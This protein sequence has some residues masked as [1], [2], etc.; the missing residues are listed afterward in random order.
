M[1]K[2]N[3]LVVL[4]VLVFLV[5]DIGGATKG[6][7]STSPSLDRREQLKRFDEALE[8]YLSHSSLSLRDVV[9]LAALY[10]LREDQY[11]QGGEVQ[12]LQFTTLAL[13]EIEKECSNLS[14]LNRQYDHPCDTNEQYQSLL[15]ALRVHE[16]RMLILLGQ[17]REA[18]HKGIAALE[19]H[20][21]RFGNLSVQ[22][23]DSEVWYG[24]PSML[25]YPREHF[26]IEEDIRSTRN[27]ERY[28]ATHSPHLQEQ[29][30]RLYNTIG[31][32][33]LSSGEASRAVPYFL[34]ALQLA[35]CMHHAYFQ[36]ARALQSAKESSSSNTLERDVAWRKEQE[37]LGI[38]KLLQQRTEILLGGVSVKSV[39]QQIDEVDNTDIGE[40]QLPK[41]S[42]DTIEVIYNR[43]PVSV[44]KSA[45]E[46]DPESEGTCSF[47]DELTYLEVLLRFGNLGPW[48][49]AAQASSHV[50]RSALYWT[51]F[52]TAESIG[53]F[54]LAWFYLQQGR[55]LERHRIYQLSK[56]ERSQ[57]LSAK[58]NTQDSDS[59]IQGKSPSMEQLLSSSLSEADFWQSYRQQSRQLAYQVTRLYF[60]QFWPPITKSNT[61]SIVAVES[62]QS[63]SNSSIP[64]FIVGFFRSGS[65]LLESLLE[66]HPVV[67]ALGE[68]SP[69]AQAVAL[70]LQPLA[71]QRWNLLQ[72]YLQPST[73]AEAK[74]NAK[75]RKQ[76][77][78]EE[79]KVWH[80]E[81]QLV[82]TQIQE[83]SERILQ[84]MKSWTRNLYNI[85]DTDGTEL[86]SSSVYRIVDKMLTN[87]RHI[88]L[89]HWVFP[90]ALILH[91][92]RD[93]ID[94]LL[95]CIRHRF[96][97]DHAA[98]TLDMESLV[99]EYVAYLMVMQHFRRILPFREYPMRKNRVDRKVKEED[100]SSE[101]I[102]ER[103]VR[104]GF[105]DVR[106]E[107]LVAEPA[108]YFQDILRLL[109]LPP[110]DL[111]DGSIREF[112]RFQS[113]RH[114]RT[115]SFLQVKQPISHRT[116]G[117][118]RKYAKQLTPTLL[119][120][121][122]EKLGMLREHAGLLPFYT[123]PSEKGKKATKRT[124]ASLSTSIDMNWM[125]SKEFDYEG[126]VR[127]LSEFVRQNRGIGI[128]STTRKHLGMQN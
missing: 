5:C 78:K 23:E 28:Q 90:Q 95:S 120:L 71:R 73:T 51:L 29:R 54:D 41:G 89:L 43:V 114:V 37:R 21:L 87:Y 16:T 109:R 56:L 81:M 128:G 9:A 106:Y 101:S 52:H 61:N 125:F 3:C 2:W 116:V 20:M 122:E 35:P 38:S 57:S 102:E 86:K 55:A 108:L 17:Y 64:I 100:E 8:Q 4:S 63:S 24:L 65:T 96:A 30:A 39:S 124:G 68:R 31:E 11:K 7:E 42:E 103:V 121:L 76:M 83:S 45:D 59:S 22:E 99:E 27:N 123:S 115:A 44:M 119:T 97:D 104:Q 117:Q 84:E 62:L 112:Y 1:W 85:S 70:H 15:E 60:P 94:T 34:H 69:F 12:S 47:G 58:A 25:S 75:Q 53:D 113:P 14:V 82:E 18:L 66:T 33:Y 98:Y 26:V 48:R 127:S 74:Q 46:V 50:I 126:Y 6:T 72:E 40:D 36:L 49:Y 107:M 118:W 13:V 111:N 88:G 19:S 93:P 110:S 10:F 32:V 77:S 91:T 105:L 79:S 67:Y 80:M 92:V